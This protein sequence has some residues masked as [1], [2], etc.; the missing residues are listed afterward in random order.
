MSTNKKPLSLEEKLNRF[1]AALDAERKAR[2]ADRK[3]DRQAREDDRKADRQARE[4]DR[5]EWAVKM[6]EL[7]SKLG[8]LAEFAVESGILDTLDGYADLDVTH[9]LPNI[10]VQAHR[11]GKDECGEID[12]IVSG[13]HD[14]VVVETKVTLSSDDI[15]KFVDKYLRNFPRW[16]ASSPHIILPDCAGKRIFGCLAYAQASSSHGSCGSKGRADYRACLWQQQQDCQ[17]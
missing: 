13:K 9:L 14:I 5:R 3:A 16:Q 12:I 8:K 4:D 11:D 2:A 15:T 6:G 1:E 10:D 17:P 7:S